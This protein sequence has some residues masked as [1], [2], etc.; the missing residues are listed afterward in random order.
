MT[1]K[2]RVP[3]HNTC[4]I[5]VKQKDSNFIPFAFHNFSIYDSKMFSKRLVDLKKGKV[6]FEI[7]PKT[8]EEYIVVKYG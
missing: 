5:N 7:I 4:N 8:N 3:A 1:G 6:K 2:F